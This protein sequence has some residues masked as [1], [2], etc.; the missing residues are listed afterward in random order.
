MSTQREIRGQVLRYAIVVSTPTLTG[1]SERMRASGPVQ[2]AVS[3]PVCLVMS[4][5]LQNATWWSR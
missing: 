5:D 3:W 4:F 1:R 2:R